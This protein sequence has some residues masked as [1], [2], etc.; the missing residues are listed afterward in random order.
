MPQVKFEKQ[1]SLSPAEAFE[2]LKSLLS[3]TSELKKI[4]PDVE[5]V[6]DEKKMCVQAKGTKISGDVSIQP[7]SADQCTV[8]IDLNIPW[9]YAPFKTLIKSKLE[10]KISEMC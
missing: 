6:V 7:D 1:I 2:K 4:D 8:K 9:A 3:N 5:L 10:E